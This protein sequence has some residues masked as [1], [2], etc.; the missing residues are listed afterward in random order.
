MASAVKSFNYS[1]DINN[2]SE[3][4]GS[5]YTGTAAPKKAP[6]KQKTVRPHIVKEKP[7]TKEDLK[8]SARFSALSTLKV[9]VGAAV[10]LVLLGMVIFGR[11]M[12]VEYASQAEELTARYEEALSENVRLTSE[13]AAMYSK[14]NISDYAENELGMIKKDDYQP[15]YFSVE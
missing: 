3:L 4:M 7:R 9:F 12:V 11:V 14:E 1:F 6:A 5:S 2:Y 10:I 15:I 8:R 13:V